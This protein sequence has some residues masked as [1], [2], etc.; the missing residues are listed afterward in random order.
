MKKLFIFTI[1]VTVYSNITSQCDMINPT[2]S[3]S[4]IV[5]TRS[6]QCSDE[7][8]YN[9]LNG[10]PNSH[11]TKT[12]R[13]MWHV[14]RKSDKTGS[15]LGTEQS[16]DNYFKDVANYINFRLSNNELP[17]PNRGSR[18]VVDTKLRI[19]HKVQFW[20][21]TNAFN[22]FQAG[23]MFP[24][25]E[26]I[27]NYIK[28]SNSPLSTFEKNNYLHVI[29]MPS[30]T[31]PI[32][33][34]MASDITDKNWIRFRGTDWVFNEKKND[35]YNFAV[36]QHGGHMLHEMGHNLGLDHNFCCG[37]KGYQQDE[38]ADNDQQNGMPPNQG[39]SNN[40]MDYRDD[41][42][43]KSFSECQ[44]NYMHY[45]LINNN[46]DLGDLL[47]DDYCDINGLYNDLIIHQNENIN[48]DGS[49]FLNSNLIINGRLNINCDVSFP[50]LSLCKIN[51]QGKLFLS[52]AKLFSNCNKL[53]HGV[54]IEQNGYFNINKG[55]IENC[56]ILVKNGGTLHLTGD[57]NLKDAKI[58][59]EQGGFI[60][61]DNNSKIN[62]INTT[63]I[64]N[65]QT[66]F[67]YGIKS[68]IGI[69][70]SSNCSTIT[71]RTSGGGAVLFNFPI[72]YLQNENISTNRIITS[73]YDI[74]VGRNVTNLKP[75]GNVNINKETLLLRPKNS[76]IFSDGFQV[77]SKGQFEI[78]F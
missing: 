13:I 63:S 60:C 64:V 26:F 69:I 41:W 57:V 37:T 35:N 27:N 4:T 51:G 70:P 48:Y 12:I 18:L 29:I 74:N 56:E 3:N 66:G 45:N 46:G 54:I 25:T 10:A 75:V 67:Q 38:C 61:F 72:C 62:F 59:V 28:P 36:S 21:S 9:I 24:E 2:S 47:V 44:I 17:S 19:T 39:S 52:D 42:D 23:L 43:G 76:V 49:R 71:N 33:G 1:L 22:I 5:T 16:I 34:G 78:S 65:L 50:K 40:Y 14:I 20:N 11:N 73:C 53:W 32:L 55:F 58:T 7:K 15:F 6:A 8:N 30:I 77:D 68:G 31:K